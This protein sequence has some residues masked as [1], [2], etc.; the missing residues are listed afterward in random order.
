MHDVETEFRER[1]EDP[2]PLDG[3]SGH[4]SD[5]GGE[6][7]HRDTRRLSLPNCH[8][9]PQSQVGRHAVHLLRAYP[10]L[11]A[12][13]DYAFAPAASGAWR[14]AYAKA[15][16]RARRLV[17]VKDQYLWG[18]HVGEMFGRAL[19]RNPGSTSSA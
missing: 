10:H 6:G 1:W 12:K 19:E 14:A 13:R 2:A 8:R 7:P 16:R 15:I 11:T 9:H 5:R 3:G 18:K 17:Y 4:R